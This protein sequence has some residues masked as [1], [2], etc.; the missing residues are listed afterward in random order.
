MQLY[1]YSFAT[2][3]FFMYQSPD[4]VKVSLDIKDTFAAY[5][6]ACPP[7][8]GF[9]QTTSPGNPCLTLYEHFVDTYDWGAGCYLSFDPPAGVV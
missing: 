3:G 6:A 5:A 7:D 1:F 4:I 2:G 8:E 9:T